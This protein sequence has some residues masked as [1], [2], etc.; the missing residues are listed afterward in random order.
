MRLLCAE[1]C[2]EAPLL[3]CNLVE[4]GHLCQ[5]W[6]NDFGLTEVQ[7]QLANREC[8]VEYSLA[9]GLALGPFQYGLGWATA[10]AYIKGLC[11]TRRR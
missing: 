8:F 3:A 6:W 2:H 1:V 4:A 9:L 10:Q 7:K 11:I 5:T